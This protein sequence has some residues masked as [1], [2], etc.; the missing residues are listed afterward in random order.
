M[1]NNIYLFTSLNYSKENYSF[2]HN[3]HMMSLSFLSLIAYRSLYTSFTMRFTNRVRINS[4][5]QHTSQPQPQSRVKWQIAVADLEHKKKSKKKSLRANKLVIWWNKNQERN[6]TPK[7]WTVRA[8]EAN[9][10]VL[11]LSK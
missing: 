4:S 2:T 9:V 6:N 11:W 7:K 3:V 8:A 10:D 1:C 5:I